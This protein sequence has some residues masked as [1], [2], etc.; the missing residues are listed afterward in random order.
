M[1]FCFHQAPILNLTQQFITEICNL[2]TRCLTNNDK[3]FYDI[4]NTRAANNIPAHLLDSYLSHYGTN[5]K[6]LG[7]VKT[8]S[9]PRDL[10]LAIYHYY[11][12]FFDLID[13][14]PVIRLQSITANTNG[15][16][17]PIHFDID[18]RVSVIHPLINHK[19]T[20]TTFY[21]HKLDILTW[22]DHYTAIKDPKWPDCDSPELFHSLPT[23]I[24]QELL[25]YN[26]T[27]AI[28]FSENLRLGLNLN[29]IVDP[30]KVVEVAK[31]EIVNDACILNVDKCHSVKICQ[32]SYTTPRL[33][34][35]W[36]FPKV[37]FRDVANA[38]HQYVQSK[39]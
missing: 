19:D 7:K 33:S 28:L 1:N 9:L 16:A 8:W 24:Q 18:K 34:L 36:K 32:S 3:D 2:D 31:V 15:L 29:N 27:H 20:F 12:D 22:Q 10:E 37:S 17:I 25:T 39:I 38:Y 35:Y 30:S 14:E 6:K 23:E 5:F 21:N 13:D 11:K 26:F 4:D